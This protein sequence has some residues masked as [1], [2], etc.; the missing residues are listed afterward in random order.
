MDADKSYEADVKTFTPDRL[1]STCVGLCR[2]P[3]CKHNVGRGGREAQLKWL[4]MWLTR[5]LTQVGIL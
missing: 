5:S 4:Q 1:A 3:L 2:M